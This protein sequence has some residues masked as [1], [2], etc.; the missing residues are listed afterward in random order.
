MV[1][2]MCDCTVS[3]SDAEGFGLSTLESMA[4]GTPIIATTTGGL[5]QQVTKLDKISHEFILERNSQTPRVQEYEH[6]FGLIPSSQGVIGSQQVPYIYEDRLNGK[7][8]VEALLRMYNMDPKERKAMGL[9]GLAHT[10]KEYN[11]EDFIERWD[12]LFMNLHDRCGSWETRKNFKPYGVE[13]F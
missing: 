3:V 13:V 1:Y 5:Q 7:D 6:G 11:F 9:R 8:V 4:C 2:N 12:N 10:Q